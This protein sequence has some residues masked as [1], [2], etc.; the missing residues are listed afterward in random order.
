MKLYV[1]YGT[2]TAGGSVHR[3]P[4]GEAHKALREAGYRPEVIRTYGL[5]VLPDIVNELAPGRRE[6]KRL[7]GRYW[8]PVL[9]TDD[10]TVVH[11][12]HKIIAWAREHPAAPPA[13]AA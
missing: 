12:S 10:G 6:V 4:C 3:H 2:W 1:C 5:G 13:A 7:T 8:V 11:D 9:V